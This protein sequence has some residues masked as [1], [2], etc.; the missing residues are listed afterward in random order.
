MEWAHYVSDI[1]G[2]DIDSYAI[3][4]MRN[5]VNLQQK[6]AFQLNELKSRAARDGKPFAIKGVFRPED[7]DLVR[8][9]KPD[10]VV[11]SNHGG[12]VETLRGSTA[13]F[14]AVHGKELAA[15]A[16][17]VWVDGGI[18]T[19]SDLAAAGNLGAVEVMI[20]RPFITALLR[21][22]SAGIREKIAEIAGR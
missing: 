12:R 9:V 22:G 11:V 7:I 5:L 8:D 13:D 10:I 17:E 4:T 14:L 3:L 16:G 21:A 18:R 6:N 20:G 1:I 19:P 2:V 15:L